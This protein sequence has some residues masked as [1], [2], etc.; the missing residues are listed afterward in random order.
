MAIQGKASI[1]TD[2]Q[3]ELPIFFVQLG[4]KTN[5]FFNHVLKQAARSN[6]LENVYVLT[7][8]NFQLY[9]GFNYIDISEYIKG[10]RE[11]D[12]VY[13][14]HSANP[15]FFEKACFDRWFIINDLT[16]DMGITKFVHADCDVVIMEDLKPLHTKFI[17]DR[18][19]GTMMFF[20][21]DGDSVTS[22]HTSF[23]NTKLISDFCEFVTSKYNDQ[24]GFEVLLQNTLSGKFLDNRNVSDMIL[25]DVFRTETK[26]S[27][28]N[29]LSLENEGISLDF[30]LNVSFNG[31]K[32]HFV[33]T[34][35]NIKKMI[36]RGESL[37]GQILDTAAE[38]QYFKFYTLHF[39]GYLTKTLIPLHVTAQNRL[40]YVSNYLMAKTS[41]FSR[42]IKLLKNKV[43]RKFT[44]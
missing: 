9:K 21:R 18:Y 28:L 14:H 41:Y 10:D 32:H 23:W 35:N 20:E 17:Q 31:C 4:N 15:Y 30:N 8:T 42:K 39:Q 29:L 33:Q 3:P 6:G 1:V 24:Q 12:Q 11:F 37:F 43:K 27:A 36:R 44:A 16:R 38:P 13:K 7:D 40:E 26:P 19:D 2:K 22:G 34:T 5:L 25:L